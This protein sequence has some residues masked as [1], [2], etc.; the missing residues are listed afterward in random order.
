[1]AS[2]EAGRSVAGS[3]CQGAVWRASQVSKAALR[4]GSGQVT[5]G[6][7][8]A[9]DDE[10]GGAEEG[11]SAASVVG[12]QEAGGDGGAGGGPKDNPILKTSHRRSRRFSRS[13]GSRPYR[14]H[15]GMPWGVAFPV[16]AFV[17][18]P[19]PLPAP[20]CKPLSVQPL[21]RLAQ[22]L[23]QACALALPC[24][25]VPPGAPAQEPAPPT[26]LT[27]STPST[28]PVPPDLRTTPRLQE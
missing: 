25:A 26:P 1:M 7:G 24:C 22:A 23:A 2:T 3:N 14:R 12:P 5:G 16:A 8:G 28:A 17:S 27:P 4:A 9:A 19:L 6:V 15:G 11:A 20:R 10:V 18:F 13:R 21:V